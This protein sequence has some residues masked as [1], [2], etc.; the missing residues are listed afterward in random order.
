MTRKIRYIIAVA[1]LC[2]ASVACTN[3]DEELFSSV[4]TGNYYNTARD[5]KRMIF[6]PFE[7]AFWSIQS[8]YTLNELTA[9][10]LVTVQRDGW[11]DD[12]GS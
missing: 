6:R 1:V 8:L 5:V 4:T 3:L 10:Q 11:W 7:H 12:G 9:D 2:S